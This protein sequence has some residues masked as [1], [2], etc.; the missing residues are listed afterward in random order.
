MFKQ[1][2]IKVIERLVR[3]ALAA[4]GLQLRRISPTIAIDLRNIKCAIFLRVLESISNWDNKYFFFS[5]YRI[6]EQNQNYTMKDLSPKDFQRLQ[7]ILSEINIEPYGL[8]AS[9]GRV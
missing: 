8:N 6:D 2:I 9:H 7:T 4:Y 3:G 1:S 5:S